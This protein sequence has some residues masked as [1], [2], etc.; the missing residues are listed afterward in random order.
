MYADYSNS[1]FEFV[2]GGPYNGLCVGDA[3]NN[4]GSANAGL[5]PCPANTYSGGW[6][7]NFKMAGCST[8]DEGTQFK[9]NHWGG[10]L[11]PGGFSNE[12]PY[13]LNHSGV[14]CVGVYPPSETD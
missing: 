9:N 5:D 10:Y 7:T 14:Y 11:A 4:S 1:Y 13:Y 2:G 12:V 6:G 8:G 3:N